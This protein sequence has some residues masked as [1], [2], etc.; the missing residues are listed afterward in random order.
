MVTL[1]ARPLNTVFSFASWS[2]CDSTNGA[3]CTVR[4]NRDRTVTASF[5]NDCDGLTEIGCARQE[6]DGEPPGGGADE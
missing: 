1:T 2:G 4:M 3:T 6:N 5:T